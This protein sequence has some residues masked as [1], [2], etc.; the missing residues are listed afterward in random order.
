MMVSHKETSHAQT[1]NLIT[2]SRCKT[3]EIALL[4]KTLS[5]TQR[6]YCVCGPII[7]KLLMENTARGDK[8]ALM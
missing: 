1:I 5:D 6:S 2:F 7:R 3:L 4:I 8:E